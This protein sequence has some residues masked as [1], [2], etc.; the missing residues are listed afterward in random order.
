MFEHF[1]CNQ[2]HLAPLGMKMIVYDKST[3]QDYWNPCEVIGHQIGPTIQHY[4]CFTC[5]ILLNR[6]ERFS[7]T[8][9]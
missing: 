1:Q 8:L 3:H 7:D 4:H 2:T 6:S 5:F 9:T